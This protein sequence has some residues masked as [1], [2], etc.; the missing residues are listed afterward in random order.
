MYCFSHTSCS[1]LN[2]NIFFN[3]Q[4]IV[5]CYELYGMQNFDDL[6]AAMFTVTSLTCSVDYSI[7]RHSFVR[8]YNS[9]VIKVLTI[10]V[11]TV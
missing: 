3:H 9:W 8:C 7:T 11:C 5:Y 1:Q 2:E 6:Y 10:R 4:R